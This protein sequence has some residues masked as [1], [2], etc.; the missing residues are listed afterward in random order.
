MP[1]QRNER[2]GKRVVQGEMAPDIVEQHR[3]IAMLVATTSMCNW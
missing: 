3:L 1:L 2:C